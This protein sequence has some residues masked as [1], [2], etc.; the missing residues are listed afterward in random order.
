MAPATGLGTPIREGLRAT[1]RKDFEAV[2]RGAL[3]LEHSTLRQMRS[4][5]DYRFHE[6]NAPEDAPEDALASRAERVQTW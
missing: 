5:I 2:L 3:D 4:E 6:W 1:W